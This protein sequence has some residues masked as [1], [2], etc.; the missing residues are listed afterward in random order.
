MSYLD[1]FP[2]TDGF[3]L[4]TKQRC[5]LTFRD[6][7]VE[8]YD[9]LRRAS[10]MRNKS[11]IVPQDSTILI[12]AF[13]SYERQ[14]QMKAGSAI[15]G[16]CF[17]AATGGEGGTLSFEVRDGCDD[18]PVFSEVVTRQTVSPPYPAQYLTK[19]LVIGAPGLVNVVICNTYSTPM[20]GQLVL[21]GG[22]P[23]L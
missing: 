21:Y 19:L 10:A 14:I 9:A 2:V 16:Y 20:Q 17:I 11:W 23:A 13:D 7:V 8:Q 15:W 3:A 12:P 6:I 22:E 1:G 18:I 4:S 5:G